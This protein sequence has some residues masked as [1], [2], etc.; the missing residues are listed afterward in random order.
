MK[1][2]KMLNSVELE[3]KT[4]TKIL[5]QWKD[6]HSSFPTDTKGTFAREGFV[7][8]LNHNSKCKGYTM[9]W[10]KTRSNSKSKP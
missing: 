5:Q 7:T 9:L 1:D 8:K 2:S 4:E 10:K 3:K 6:K